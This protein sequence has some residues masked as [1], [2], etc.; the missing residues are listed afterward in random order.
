LQTTSSE[1]DK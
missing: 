1:L